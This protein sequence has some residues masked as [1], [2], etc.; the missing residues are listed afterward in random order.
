MEK[1][2][3]IM[4][5]DNFNI[6]Q[7]MLQNKDIKAFI[8]EIKCNEYSKEQIEVIREGF[9]IGLTPGEVNVYANPNYSVWVMREIKYALSNGVTIDVV[10][11]Y[12]NYRLEKMHQIYIGHKEGLS[13]EQIALYDNPKMLWQQMEQIRRG[14]ED[15]LTLEQ[16]KTYADTEI[17]HNKMREIRTAFKRG[18]TFEQI[19]VLNKPCFDDE[20]M[21]E[22]RKAFE[23]GLSFEQVLSFADPEYSA[24]TMSWILIAYS[25]G[26]EQEKIDLMLDKRFETDQVI[27]I[28]K[29]MQCG[30]TLDNIKLY[31][32]PAYAF[33]QMDIIRMSIKQFGTENVNLY[34]NPKFEA[35]AMEEIY[36]G[37]LQGYPPETIKSF[38]KEGIDGRKMYQLRMALK[39]MTLERVEELANSNLTWEEVQN[40][41]EETIKKNKTSEKDILLALLQN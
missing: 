22:I 18:L 34:L 8:N 19:A 37:M 16:V 5:E 39:D 35:S 9:E 26:Y 17:S 40:I 23:E 13:E 28:Y 27:R 4:I 41:R 24:E 7:N 29:G 20:Q 11:K 32:D 12:A 1:I 15:G 30:L 2:V 38:A 3:E 25:E 31:A 21:K 14:F 10:M 36:K 6:W 33:D